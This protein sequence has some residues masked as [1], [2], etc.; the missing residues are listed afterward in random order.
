MRTLLIS[1]LMLHDNDHGIGTN[2]GEQNDDD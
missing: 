2:K 1:A